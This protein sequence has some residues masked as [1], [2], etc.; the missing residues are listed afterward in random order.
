MNKDNPISNGSDCVGT[1][2]RDGL[3]VE[4]ARRNY[5]G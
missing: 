5:N 2:R 3:A 4:T 1:L